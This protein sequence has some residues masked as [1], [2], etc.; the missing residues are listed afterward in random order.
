MVIVDRRHYRSVCRYAST[1]C[2]SSSVYFAELRD[3]RLERIVDGELHL[4]RRP[5]PVRSRPRR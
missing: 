1:L 2:M 4:A 5:R 3:V